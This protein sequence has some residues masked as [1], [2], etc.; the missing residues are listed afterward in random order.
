[1]KRYVIV[2]VLV[3]LAACAT[4][5]PVSPA[6]PDLILHSG[7]IFTADRDRLWVE[8]LA[9]RGDRIVAN[10]SSEAVGRLAGASTRLMDLGGRVVIPGI[11]D[12]HLHQ[13]DLFPSQTVDLTAAGSFREVAGRLAAM[14]D[15]AGWIRAELPMPLYDDPEANRATLDAAVPSRPVILTLLGDHAALLNSAALR[16][17]SISDNTPDPPAGWYGRDAAGRLNG[18]LYEYAL[19]KKMRDAQRVHSDEEFITLLEAFAREAARYGITSVQNMSLPL[20][21]DRSVAVLQRTEPT[22]RWR[23][24]RIQTGEIA[25]LAPAKPAPPSQRVRASGIKYILDGTPLERGSAVREP[26]ADRPGHSGRMNFTPSEIDRMLE[27]SRRSGEPLLLHAVGDRAVAEVLGAIRRNGGAG[28]WA[29]M[30]L[31]IEH[32]DLLAPDLLDAVKELGVVIV[33]NPSHFMLPVLAVRYG[34]ERQRWSEPMQTLLER[35][36]PLAIGSDGPINPYL[37]IMFAAINAINPA[38][39]LTREQAVEAYTRGAAYA[40][41]AE[42]EKGTLAPDMLAD[43]A[44]L[45]QDIFTVPL[46]QLPAT[47]SVLTM[48]GGKIIYERK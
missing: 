22:I 46:Q 27:Q 20:Q 44:V 45:S 41:F 9:I 10:G 34:K 11:N 37:N 39:A 28:V 14:R 16:E 35:G 15:G 43:L 7:R 24:I 30:R 48:V 2:L 6:V 26:Y 33:Q 36:I 40:E 1:M 17:W 42:R 31:R 21:A 32:G 5:T 25:T 19:W 47:E 13:P 8:A 4:R 18:W 29:P 23:V 12:A 3:L 38:E